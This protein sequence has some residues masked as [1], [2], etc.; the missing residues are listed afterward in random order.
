MI[1]FANPSTSGGISDLMTRHVIGAIATPMQYNRISEEW[2]W[3]AD[4]GCFGK[5]YPGDAGYLAWLDKMKPLAGRC[6]FATAPDVIADAAATLKRS[7]PFLSEIR[8]RGFPAAFIGQD[9][10]ED[11]PVPWSEFDAFFIGGST[12]WKLGEAA[13]HLAGEA[14]SRGKWVHMG[15]V[16]SKKRLVYAD[17]I[18]CHSADG[19]F[20]VFGP[21]KNIPRL[22]KWLEA[23]K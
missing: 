23:V 15:R 10:Q 21:E 12:E 8:G 19:T 3:C 5:G 13:A 16:N 2:N 14:R 7:R 20:L 6:A 1:Y 18:G 9:G 22:L 4:N 17:E 11:L